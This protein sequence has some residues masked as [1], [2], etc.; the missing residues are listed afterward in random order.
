L[1]LLNA[2]TATWKW[3]RNN[4]RLKLTADEITISRRDSS[5]K[6]RRVPY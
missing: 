3:N 5:C 6:N 4:D 2:T 1:E